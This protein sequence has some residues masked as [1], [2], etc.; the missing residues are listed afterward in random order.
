VRV[1]CQ[2]DVNAISKIRDQL[3]AEALQLFKTVDNWWIIPGAE[4]EQDKRYDADSWETNIIAWLSDFK[5]VKAISD[6]PKVLTTSFILRDCFR[7]ETQKHT[8]ADQTRIGA[9]MRRLGY[10]PKQVRVNDG[11]RIRFFEK[12]R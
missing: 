2:I 12:A 5:I 8:R 7:I 11:H 3:W 9:V 6:N 1:E 10:H 4:A